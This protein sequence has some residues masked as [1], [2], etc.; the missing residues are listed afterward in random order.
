[1]GK[2]KKLFSDFKAFI[3]KGN[4]VDMAVGV[5]IA[6]SFTAIVNALSKGIIMPLVNWILYLAGGE[7][8]EPLVT[9]L[10]R[11]EMLDAEG[12]AILDTANSIIIDWSTFINNIIDFLIIAV[13]LFVIIKI[14][15]NIKN[16]TAGITEKTKKQA[17]KLA[18]KL[19]KKGATK[20]EAEAQ[21][22]AQIEAAAAEASAPAPAKPTT[23]ELLIEIRDLLAAQNAKKEE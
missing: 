17:A 18:K 1:M 6:S 16:I 13:V 2:I 8:G 9:V 21:A 20:E 12:N 23:E 19:Q 4:V 22:A 7:T 3:T 10:K 14:F 15:A 5:I 11:V